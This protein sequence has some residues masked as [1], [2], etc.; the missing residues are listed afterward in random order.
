MAGSDF[1]VIFCF[2]TGNRRNIKE[3]N[4]NKFSSSR[5]VKAKEIQSIPE[6]KKINL[7]SEKKILPLEEKKKKNPLHSKRDLPLQKFGVGTGVN[8]VSPPKISISST[9][10]ASI[11]PDVSGVN[12]RVTFN[13]SNINHVNK[14]RSSLGI[15]PH[16]T[17]W[18][19]FISSNA[20][21]FSLFPKC[22]FAIPILVIMWSI[23]YLVLRYLCYCD[24][25]CGQVMKT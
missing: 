20:P 4:A 5:I 23:H 24:Q 10:I 19:L 8:V 25:L 18:F 9:Q 16:S 1:F 11:H 15:Q 13:L 3:S 22:R 21:E 17:P 6:K 7:T 2:R 14:L 12:K